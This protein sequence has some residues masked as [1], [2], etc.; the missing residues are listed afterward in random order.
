MNGKNSRLASAVLSAL[1][2]TQG[3]LIVAGVTFALMK[4]RTDADAAFRPAVVASA[5]YLATSDTELR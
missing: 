1:L 5:S 2:Y 3:L 4:D